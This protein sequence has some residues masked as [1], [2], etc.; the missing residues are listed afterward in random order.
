MNCNILC[1]RVAAAALVVVV[2]AQA[3]L[4][5]SAETLEWAGADGS[6]WTDAGNWQDASGNP[7]DWVDGSTAV[8]GGQGGGRSL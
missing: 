5:A 6:G 4:I 7:T 1:G 8:F 3:T 2:S